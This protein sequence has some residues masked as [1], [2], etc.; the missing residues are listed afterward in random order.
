[1]SKERKIKIGFVKTTGW[2]SLAG[3]FIPGFTTFGTFGLQSFITMLGIECSDSWNL[4][5]RITSAGCILAPWLFFR[6]IQKTELDN[7]TLNKWLLL[8]NVI[9]Y[10]FLQASITSF[11]TNGKTLCYVT[12]G[13]NGLEIIFAGLL[14]IPVLLLLSFMFQQV[15][16][17]KLEQ[18]ELE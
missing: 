3:L 5:F 13:Q 6:F 10:T 7:E 9:E 15:Q 18:T 1:M 4:L 8:F 12:D 14:A 17:A 2:F 16:K 11:F